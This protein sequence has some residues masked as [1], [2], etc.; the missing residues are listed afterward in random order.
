MYFYNLISLL[1]VFL[2]LPDIDQ[3]LSRLIE[4]LGLNR[5]IKHLNIG[6]N[7]EGREK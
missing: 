1:S 6:Q 2:F 3:H 4:A 7:F 5:S